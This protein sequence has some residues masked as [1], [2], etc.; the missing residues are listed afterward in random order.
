MKRLLKW[1]GVAL[2]SLVLLAGM[3]A[4][5]VWLA[6]ER[7]I[8]EVYAK[9]VSTFVYDA[10]TADLEEGR[11]IATISG[12][13][14]GCHGVAA[15]G[16]VFNDDFAFGLFHAPN[17]TQQFAAMSD[18]DLDLTIR[19]GIRR[20]GRS[21][22]IMPSASFHHM[23]DEAFNDLVGFIRSLPRTEGP[24]FKVRPGIVARYFLID[25]LFEP[26][27]RQVRDE[28]PWIEPGALPADLEHG[29]YLSLTVCSECHGMQHEGFAS[30]TPGLGAVLAYSVED[31]RRLMR[32]G[33]PIGERELGLMAEVAKKRF[34]LM[35]D[36]EIES[37]HRYLQAY[38]RGE[39][40]ATGGA[41]LGSSVP[42]QAGG[43][44]SRHVE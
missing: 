35:T 10:A 11:R 31:F 12:C 13:Y 1:G 5:Y 7:I 34:A 37:L 36:E 30:F 14:D 18:A 40:P 23:T 29:R 42:R 9:P 8:D 16:E 27:A 39:I 6:G 32:E 3:A 17:L 26:Q 15:D 41:R 4:A 24:G 22:L 2:G 44:V 33:I 20:D 28:A 38:F 21:N 19:H 25:G 43:E